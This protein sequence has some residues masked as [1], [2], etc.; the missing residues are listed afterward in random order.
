[1]SLEI[2]QTVLGAFIRKAELLETTRLRKE[3]FHEMDGMHS[4]IFE[5]LDW[6]Y[7]LSPVSMLDKDGGFDFTLLVE[8]YK[9]K[10]AQLGNVS[11]LFGLR[12]SSLNISSLEHY[13][14]I[15][16]QTHADYLTK[17]ITQRM[18]AGELEGKAAIDEL[19]SIQVL[20]EKKRES[21]MKKLYDLFQGHNKELMRRSTK[22]DGVTGKRTATERIDKHTNGHQKGNLIIVGARPSIGK[23]Q[24]LLNDMLRSNDAP[25]FSLEMG[26]MDLV[27]RYASIISGIDNKK[28]KSGLLTDKDWSDYSKALDVIENLNIHIDD[29][30]NQTLSYIRNEIKRMVKQNPNI[31][32]YIDYLQ[33]IKVEQRM[34]NHE[35]VKHVSESLKQMAKEFNIPIV[36]ISAVGRDSEKSTDKRPTLS[37]LRE[38]GSIESDADVVMLLYRDDYYY[39]DA[40]KGVMEVIFAKGR[41]IGTDTILVH[42]NKANG[43]VMD[44]SDDELSTI[45]NKLVEY[46]REKKNKR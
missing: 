30:A 19:A 40:I 11:Y 16:V 43:R 28:I 22:K 25:L 2:E 31:T 20:R 45:K 44:F 17:D 34:P 18:M 3:Y 38:S 13:E 12:Q 37:D 35:R 42:F 15:I 27:D 5:I 41:N 14:D 6:A 4:L 46:E 24:F 21:G 29:S 39:A 8:H 1:M 9:D 33:L 36:A 26:S 7:K 32:V 23:T 10:I